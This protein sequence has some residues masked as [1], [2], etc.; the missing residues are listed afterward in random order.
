MVGID[1]QLF[2]EGCN[3]LVK[4]GGRFRYR[5]S[6][7]PDV[8]LWEIAIYRD[9]LIVRLMDACDPEVCSRFVSRMKRW[10]WAWIRPTS[11]GVVHDRLEDPH[12]A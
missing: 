8:R 1:S 12:P 3:V 9:G 11:S 6:A 4:S 2:A 5:N 7:A 10:A